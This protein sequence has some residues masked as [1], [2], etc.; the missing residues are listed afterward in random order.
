MKSLKSN[1]SSPIPKSNRTKTTTEIQQNQIP[2]RRPKIS[3]IHAT[4][5]AGIQK[6]NG[7]KTREAANKKGHWA[8]RI[9][10]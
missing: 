3:T 10:N 1:K 6:Q 2:T 5:V 7:P 9:L 4:L 8:R